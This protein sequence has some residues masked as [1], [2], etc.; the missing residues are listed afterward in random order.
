M[1]HYSSFAVNLLQGVIERASGMDFED[2]MRAH[3]WGPAGMLR[4]EFDRPRR[5]TP[6]R[7]R[8]YLMVDGNPV[9]HPY[10]DVTY[11]FASG[12]MMS[13]AEDL[14]C[15]AMAFNG[16]RLVRPETAQ[17]MIRP[18]LRGVPE[19]RAPGQSEGQEVNDRQQALMWNVVWDGSAFEGNG[20]GHMFVMHGGS[21][22]GFGASL[23]LDPK[24]DI[25]VAICAN[26]YNAPTFEPLI[27]ELFRQTERGDG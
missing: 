15:F 1:H 22:K 21:V 18:Q 20:R 19:Y 11:K 12:G 5:I 9:N 13:T 3:V 24:A 16:G 25:A 14:V 27:A 6:G 23:Y 10:E 17:E 2:Y 26:N 4:T 7:A 8:S